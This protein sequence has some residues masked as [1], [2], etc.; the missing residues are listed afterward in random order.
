MHRVDPE[1]Q[2]AELAA[3]KGRGRAITDRGTSA[4]SR[5]RFT[6]EGRALQSTNQ[7]FRDIVRVERAGFSGSRACFL[8]DR[9]PP[10]GGEDCDVRQGL[11]D[12]ASL[13]RDPGCVSNQHR[14]LAD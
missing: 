5:R 11:V 10:P 13:N 1:R 6:R 14:R 2:T 7:Q 3:T 4:S 12:H 8:Y 9:V